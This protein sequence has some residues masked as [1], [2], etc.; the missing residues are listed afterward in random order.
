MKLALHV[1]MIL[2]TTN[3]LEVTN[4]QLRR[5]VKKRTQTTALDLEQLSQKYIGL[6]FRTD[7]VSGESPG[8]SAGGGDTCPSGSAASS[9][10]GVD[11]STSSSGGGGS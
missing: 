3:N 10:P 8:Q 11:A 1:A 4:A 2:E 7:L 9:S 5:F 6:Q